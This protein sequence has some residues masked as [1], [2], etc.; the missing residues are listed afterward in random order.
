[1]LYWQG[2]AVPQAIRVGDWKLYLDKLKEI[3]GSDKGPV[4]VHLSKDPTEKYNL[5]E[6]HPDKVKE[7]KALA[8]KLLAE[9]EKNALSLGGPPNTRKSSPKRGH[10]LK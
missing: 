9:I 1:L 7:M 6:Q 2:W 3:P 5:S 10:W 8:D 4:L